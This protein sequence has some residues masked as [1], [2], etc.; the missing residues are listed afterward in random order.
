MIR[1]VLYLNKQM[2]IYKKKVIKIADK[3]RNCRSLRKAPKKKER[4]IL[5]VK[6]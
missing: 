4:T 2:M 3:K 1:I 5:S 6:K